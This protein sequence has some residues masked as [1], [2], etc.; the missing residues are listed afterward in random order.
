MEAV[1]SSIRT[2]A[3]HQVLKLLMG[4][5]ERSLG[6]P[7]LEAQILSMKG[8]ELSRRGTWL[9]SFLTHR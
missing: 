8:T 1:A 5:I 4:L 3:A 9:C 7:S 2:H 6:T